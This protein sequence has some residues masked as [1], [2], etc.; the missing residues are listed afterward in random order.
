MVLL[1]TLKHRYSWQPWFAG[2]L[3]DQMSHLTIYHGRNLLKK[4]T[5]VISQLVLPSFKTNRQVNYVP[6]ADSNC[7]MSNTR[8]TKINWSRSRYASETRSKEFVKVLYN[9]NISASYDKILSIN[10]WPSISNWTKNGRH[11]RSIHSIL[12][13]LVISYLLCW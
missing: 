4:M 2:F 12:N 3:S 13:F 6:K 7:S 5:E 11:W 9:L 8:D 1:R 10:I